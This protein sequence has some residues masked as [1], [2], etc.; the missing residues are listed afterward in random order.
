MYD[1]GDKINDQD[2]DQ[3]STEKRTNK[4]K[5]NKDFHINSYKV[6]EPTE[7]KD[8]PSNPPMT[9]DDVNYWGKT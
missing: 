2:D 8:L 5:L 1:T 9:K 4:D 3:K 7:N 6:T